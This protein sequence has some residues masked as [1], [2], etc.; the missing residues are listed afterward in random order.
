MN[1][2]FIG[3]A[4][5]IAGMLEGIPEGTNSW[6]CLCPVHNGHSLIV[7]EGTDGRVLFKCFGAECSYFAIRAALRD[8]ELVVSDT[9]YDRSRIETPKPRRRS[10]ENPDSLYQQAQPGAGTPVEGYLRSRGITLPVP[11]VLR[12]H[13][14]APHRW[15][16]YFAAM[17]ALVVGPDEAP[18]GVHLTFIKRDGSGRYPLP[19]KSME[20]EIRG[21]VRGGSV[22]LT[23]FIPGQTLIVAEG[24]E[25][26]LSC[27]QLFN[28]PAWAAL[29]T[30]GLR[31]LE[32]PP[33]VRNVV[34]AADNDMN[35]A[36]QR[37]ALEAY[38]RWTA[39]G[40]SIRI[41]VPPLAGSDFNDVLTSG[42]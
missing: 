20:R 19:D 39:E 29:S 35:G 41:A 28:L 38:Q 4:E 10:I 13:P 30:S 31:A 1:D 24:I 16:W 33:A 36:G 11:L 26:A 25:T 6:R 23:P 37:A 22:R 27:A 7:S 34:V 18:L 40:R 2:F 15:G 8:R 5:A 9:L 12:Y 32:L 14:R 42:A 21:S 17:I 3:T